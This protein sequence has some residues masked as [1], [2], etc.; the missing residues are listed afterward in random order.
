MPAIDIKILNKACSQSIRFNLV[1]TGASLLIEVNANRAIGAKDNAK[2]LFNLYSAPSDT[3]PW[4]YEDFSPCIL[5]DEADLFPF[6]VGI[7][8]SSFP[9]AK[10]FAKTPGSG[11]ADKPGSRLLF[12]KT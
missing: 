9:F 12:F 8:V 10:K 2:V 1:F 6:E 7:V 11:K 3:R 5:L 4:K